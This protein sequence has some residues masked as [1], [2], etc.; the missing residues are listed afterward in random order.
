MKE[1]F[2]SKKA[3]AMML[4]VI[5]VIAAGFTGVQEWDH[6]IMEVVGVVMAYLTAQGIADFGKGFPDGP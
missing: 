3:W 1:F 4:A 6:S 5:G 2:K